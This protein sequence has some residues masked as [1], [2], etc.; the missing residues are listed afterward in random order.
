M[1]ICNIAE[2]LII[3]T[4]GILLARENKKRDELQKGVERD[5]DS[6]AFSDMTDRENVSILLDFL[7][8]IFKHWSDTDDWGADQ[9]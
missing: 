5:L 6:T 8:Q 1:I 7:H 2:V 4:L 9:L 3:L